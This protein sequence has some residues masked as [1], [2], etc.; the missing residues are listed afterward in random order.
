KAV[1]DGVNKLKD[2]KRAFLMITHYQRLLDYI[3]PD[4]V[5]VLSNGDLIH[6]GD[7]TLPLKLEQEGYAWLKEHAE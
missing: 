3:E 6:S 5:H 4:F 1:A 2:G 7:K